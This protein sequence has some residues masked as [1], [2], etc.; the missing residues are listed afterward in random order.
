MKWNEELYLSITLEFANRKKPS[1][2]CGLQRLNVEFEYTRKSSNTRETQ[3]R[4]K[5]T[6]W[7]PG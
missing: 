7:L 4:I 2:L 5:L 6:S 3:P 1:D